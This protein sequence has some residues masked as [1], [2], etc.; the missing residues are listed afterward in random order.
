MTANG[1]LQFGVYLG[2]LLAC[3]KPLGIYMARVYSG[4]APLL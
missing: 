2:I 3:V 1:F 4:R